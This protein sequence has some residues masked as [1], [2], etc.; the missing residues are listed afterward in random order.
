MI[1]GSCIVCGTLNPVTTER[2]TKQGVLQ[3]EIFINQV[4]L[5]QAQQ[6][7]KKSANLEISLLKDICI[8]TIPSQAATYSKVF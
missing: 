2:Y 6:S 7:R 4:Y 3:T 1:I 8:S 5:V